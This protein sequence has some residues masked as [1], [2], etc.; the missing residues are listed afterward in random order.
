MQ[1]GDDI[2]ERAQLVLVPPDKA[3]H[4]WWGPQRALWSSL[5]AGPALSFV[6]WMRRQPQQGGSRLVRVPHAV[7]A[8]SGRPAVWKV[9]PCPQRRPPR[10]ASPRGRLDGAG[11]ASTAESAAQA[12]QQPWEA[13]RSP[14]PSALKA[15][16]SLSH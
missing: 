13:P 1:L 10:R 12:A 7:F 11:R 9:G 4:A 6:E 5:T 14:R 2:G 16:I 8:L 3:N 15:R